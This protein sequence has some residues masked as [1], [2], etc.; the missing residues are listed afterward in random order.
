MK[1]AR[2]RTHE[3]LLQSGQLAVAERQERAQA[4]QKLCKKEIKLKDII[5][6]D[7]QALQR[8][9]VKMLI[10]SCPGIGKNKS[11]R[12]MEDLNISLTRRIQGL[13]KRQKEA[14]IQW[15]DNHGF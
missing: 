4:K 14:L 15:A 1:G 10:E 6:S 13:G 12:I 7:S 3:E 2:L 11:P 8:M 9:R 5:N